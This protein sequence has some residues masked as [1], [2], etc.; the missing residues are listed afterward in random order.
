MSEKQQTSS[1]GG[2]ERTRPR[3]VIVGAGFGG[4]SA[5]RGLRRAELDVT[6]IDRQNHHLF[7]PLL[8]QVATAA[9]SPA[10][11]AV[12]V[13][14]LFRG[15]RNIRVLMDEV[16][17]VDVEG[18]VVLS[19]SGRYK[20]DYLVLA[21]GSEYTY[22][23]Q[24]RWRAHSV[25]LKTLE[26]ALIMRE[27]ILL[28]FERA[29]ME[30]DEA[31]R[32]RLMRFVIIGGGPTGVELA[33]AIAELAKST[34]VRDFRHI[35]PGETEIILLE[36]GPSLLSEFPQRL[37]DFAQRALERKGVTVRLE[38]PVKDIRDDGVVA[39][40]GDALIRAATVLWAGGTKAGVVSD[41]LGAEADRAG[42]VKI[43][44][45][46]SVPGHPEIFVIG[47]AA[48]CAPPGEAPLPGVA[49]VAKQQGVYVAK[50]IRQR[51]AGGLSSEPF[52]YRDEGMLA[53]IGRGAAVANLRWIKL[54]GWIA[55][56]FW[57][58]VHIYFLIGFRTRMMVFLNW[59]WAYFT[60]GLGA[61]L[62]TG[63]QTTQRPDPPSD[64][65]DS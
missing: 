52:S 45:D 5:A 36:A 30:A 51:A 39:G 16:I 8:Y 37:T 53:T 32:R 34:L 35:V 47:D 49:P 29:E 43:G 57:G 65:R 3:V 28:A 27:R 18:R 54:T 9:V 41:W 40:R 38:T 11:V 63:R 15:D 55:W 20:Y 31:E 46:L 13:R 61:R 44:A 2:S 60:Y 23:G 22:F 21:T 12:P 17:D 33:G 10:D 64:S 14:S 62:I 42:R 25:S 48:R 56:M 19:R 50:T 24:N 58:L 26:D 4:L 59:V 7:Q 6:I 1:I